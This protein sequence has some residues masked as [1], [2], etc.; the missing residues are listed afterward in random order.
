MTQAPLPDDWY[1]IRPSIPGDAKFIAET[2]ARVFRPSN[3]AHVTW[4]REHTPRELEALGRATFGNT[5]VTAEADG[6][7]IGFAFAEG[8][9]LRCVYVKRDFR[10]NGIGLR[11]LWAIGLDAPF[12]VADDTGSWRRWT[13]HHGFAWDVA[14]GRR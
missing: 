2:T 7:I 5:A 6:V 3:E 11:M 9:R 13:K 12:Q 1:E 14:G 4:L 8:R 10:G